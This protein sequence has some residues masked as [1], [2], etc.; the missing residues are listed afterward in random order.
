VL[1]SARFQLSWY[2]TR[3]T[4][5]PGFAAA[6][7]CQYCRRRNNQRTGLSLIPDRET[8]VDRDCYI[9]STG[10]Q[11]GDNGEADDMKITITE[12]GE[13]VGFSRLRFAGNHGLK[14]NLIPGRLE[15]LKSAIW[16]FIQTPL[17]LILDQVQAT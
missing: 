8:G 9:I 7:W 15:N 17:I 1:Q 3:T 10:Y 2:N 4:V 14:G 13:Q 11:L 12:T 16:S 5:I 6:G